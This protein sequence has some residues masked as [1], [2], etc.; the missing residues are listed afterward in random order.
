MK[1]NFFDMSFN[2]LLLL[3][4]DIPLKLFFERYYEV[5]K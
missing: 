4:G 3:F 1:N 5:G 2:E